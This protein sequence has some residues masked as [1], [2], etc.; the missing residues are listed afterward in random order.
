M[1]CPT[2]LVAFLGGNRPISW[3]TMGQRR[4]ALQVQ[5]RKYKIKN[6]IKIIINLVR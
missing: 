4:K 5:F 1:V 6:K 2:R 3:Y